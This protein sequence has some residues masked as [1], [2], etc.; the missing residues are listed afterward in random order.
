M[1]FEFEGFFKR[2]CIPPTID[3]CHHNYTYFI[4][5]PSS[6]FSVFYYTLNLSIYL[7]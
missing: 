7:V 3:F 1:Y 2:N 5:K 4:E 6:G